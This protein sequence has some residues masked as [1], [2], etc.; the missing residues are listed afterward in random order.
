MDAFHV[1]V[2]AGAVR[3]SMHVQPRASASEIAGT[4]EAAVRALVARSGTS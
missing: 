1:D 4:T 2:R 3:V